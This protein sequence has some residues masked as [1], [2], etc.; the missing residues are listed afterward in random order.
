MMRFAKRKIGWLR[1]CLAFAVFPPVAFCAEPKD[2]SAPAVRFQIPPAPRDYLWTMIACD[3]QEERF[4]SQAF[5]AFLALTAKREI[6]KDELRFPVSFAVMRPDY[7]ILS[8]AFYIAPNELRGFEIAI[9]RNC[10][11]E[12]QGVFNL[13]ASVVVHKEDRRQGITILVVKKK[14]PTQARQQ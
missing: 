2:V 9:P 8:R 5:D 4:V 13:N 14:E 10:L 11:I 3:E 1:A 7:V 12:R 6:G